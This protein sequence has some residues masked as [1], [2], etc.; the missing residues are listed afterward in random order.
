[1]SSVL[2]IKKGGVFCPFGQKTP[3]CYNFDPCIS[4]CKAA[5]MEQDAGSGHVAY[6]EAKCVAGLL[7]A[8]FDGV[9]VKKKQGG[10]VGDIE[11]GV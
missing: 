2:E 9:F 10:G 3:F 5:G 11:A 7:Q 4:R 6:P 1:M 8:V